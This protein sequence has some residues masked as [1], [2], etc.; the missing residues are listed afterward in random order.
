MNTYKITIIGWWGAYPS[1]GEAT[2]G[3]LLQSDDRNILVDCGSGVLS[4]L[5][6]YI[7]LQNLHAVVLSHYHWDHVADIGCLQYAARILMDLGDRQKPLEIYGHAEDENFSGLSYLQCSR[8]CAIDPR[9]AL[10]LGVFKLTFS[11]NVHPDPC[12]SIRIE[13]ANRCMAYIADTAW[14]DDLIRIAQNADLLLCESSLYDEY[15]GMIPG[16][17]TAGEAGEIASR[18]GVKHLVLT[19]L[20]HFGNHDLLLEQAGK[21]FAGKIELATTGKVWLL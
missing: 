7:K 17:L 3:Y 13:Q 14:T 20:P 2:S 4:H 8:G 11:R 18:A 10:Q 16:H 1:A 12:F 6:N 19:H 15:L 9:T 5:Q 21:K